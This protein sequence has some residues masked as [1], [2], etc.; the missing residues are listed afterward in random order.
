MIIRI[1]L[2]LLTLVFLVGCENPDWWTAPL[3]YYCTED[4]MV[5][6]DR[7]TAA[8]GEHTQWTGSF[9]YGTAIMRRCSVKQTPRRMSDE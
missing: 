2:A 1:A 7:E 5:V 8:C 3:D 4:E 9:C 6:V